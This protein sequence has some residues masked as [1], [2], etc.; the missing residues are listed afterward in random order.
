MNGQHGTVQFG[1]VT[2]PVE[3]W[4]ANMRE[5]MEAVGKALRA[6]FRPFVELT[7]QVNYIYDCAEYAY[8][9]HHRRLPGSERTARLRKK[10]R[11]EVLRWYSRHLEKHSHETKEHRRYR[12][13]NFDSL[14]V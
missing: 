10:R 9:Q 4:A 14:G 2:L 11:T 13:A 12:E 3:R 6:A 8:L 1:G 5:S 7:F